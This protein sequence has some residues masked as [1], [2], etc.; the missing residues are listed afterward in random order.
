EDGRSAHLP[1]PN[2]QLPIVKQLLAPA[3][4]TFS[5]SG[6]TITFATTIP[7]TISHILH[8]TNV[9]RGV[10]YF[11][12]QAGAAYTGTYASPVLT[13]LCST[14]GHADADKLEIF[15][16][17]ALTTLAITVAS[18]PSHAVTNAGTFAVQAA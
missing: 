6:K 9:T 8:V 18:V 13:L 3:N 15:Y 1:S 4:A 17:D 10:L 14:S 7:S 11:Q 5:A 12:P 2:Y 16:D